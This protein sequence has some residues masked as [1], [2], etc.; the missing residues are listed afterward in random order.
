MHSFYFNFMKFEICFDMR[1]S[2]F[3]EIFAA[4]LPKFC[5]VSPF[6]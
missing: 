4:A 3:E 1:L 5:F 6:V 2:S